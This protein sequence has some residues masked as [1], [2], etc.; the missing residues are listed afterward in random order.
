MD[1]LLHLKL[2]KNFSALRTIRRRLFTI[3]T[4][5]DQALDAATFQVDLQWTPWMPTFKDTMHIIPIGDEIGN[6]LCW[7]PES[8]FDASMCFLRH[9]SHL[10]NNGKVRCDLM[11]DVLYPWR[12]VTTPLMQVDQQHLDDFCAHFL[13][14]RTMLRIEVD[15]KQKALEPGTLVLFPAR[16]VEAHKQRGLV[17][18][19]GVNGCSVADRNCAGTASQFRVVVIPTDGS[20][21]DRSRMELDSDVRRNVVR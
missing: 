16:H 20:P 17:D 10:K 4:L 7:S 9:Y 3:R 8:I 1:F 14:L 18:G 13:W 11:F 2:C 12:I 15:G 5:F 19:Y 6:A 21:S